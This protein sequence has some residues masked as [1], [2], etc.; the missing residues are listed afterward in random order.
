VLTQNLST[1]QRDQR[2]TL[3]STA[4]TFQPITHRTVGSGSTCHPKMKPLKVRLRLHQIIRYRS[5]IKPFGPSSLLRHSIIADMYLNPILLPFPHNIRSPLP[6]KNKSISVLNTLNV[7]TPASTAFC[8]NEFHRFTTQQLAPGTRVRFPALGHCL[9]GV[10]TFSPVS[11]WVSSGCSG[12]LPQSERCAG[13]VD[14]P[15]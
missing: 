8:G 10:C 2:I 11:A 15:C 7:Y 5:R 9:C 12:F 3:A 14:W 13:Q 6:I 1:L 4:R